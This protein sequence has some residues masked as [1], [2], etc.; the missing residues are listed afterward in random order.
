MDPTRRECGQPVHDRRRGRMGPWEFV[1]MSSRQ[2]HFSPESAEPEG[3]G[4][5]VEVW[6][7]EGMRSLSGRGESEQPRQAL[8][9]RQ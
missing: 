3:M 4:G 7:T 9:G 5:G 6:G 1:R 8:G 2:L